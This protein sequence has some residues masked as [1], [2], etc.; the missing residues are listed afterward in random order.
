MDLA[1]K[2]KALVEPDSEAL[3]HLALADYISSGQFERHLRRVRRI[4]ATQRRALIYNLKQT[5]REQITIAPESGGSH[6][7]VRFHMQDEDDS[8][9]IAALGA[10]LG[11]ASTADYY[12]G[13]APK[14]EFIIDFSLLTPAEIETAVEQFRSQLR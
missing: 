13:R 4:Y 12:L 9:L 7:L 8:I 10:G 5:F 3:E 14:G 11:M 6:Q 2:A 1:A